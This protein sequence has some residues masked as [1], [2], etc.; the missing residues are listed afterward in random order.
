MEKKLHQ[1]K[2]ILKNN[3]NNKIRIIRLK[4]IN[5]TNNINKNKK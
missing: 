1:K 5:I 2:I 4:K 3:K